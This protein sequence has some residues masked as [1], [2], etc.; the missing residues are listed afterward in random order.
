MIRLN[1]GIPSANYIGG[2]PVNCDPRLRE[3][4]SSKW[5][6]SCLFCC[7]GFIDKVNLRCNSFC[8]DVTNK[9]LFLIYPFIDSSHR[10]WPHSTLKSVSDLH[11]LGIEGITAG[12]LVI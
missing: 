5:L 12:L 6:N 7:A 4:T 10:S 2:V 11:Y 9:T 3:A 8:L 1:E